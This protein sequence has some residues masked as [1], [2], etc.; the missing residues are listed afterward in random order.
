MGALGFSGAL[1]LGG[2][3][4]GAAPPHRGGPEGALFAEEA[5]QALLRHERGL[6]VDG[7]HHVNKRSKARVLRL[8]FL[9]LRPANESV[10]SLNHTP[11]HGAAYYFAIAGV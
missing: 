10:S 11:L 2:G 1:A 8:H 3:A 4:A 6:G 5:P 7:G 9:S